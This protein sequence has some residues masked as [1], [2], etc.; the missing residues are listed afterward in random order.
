MSQH[1]HVRVRR[2]IAVSENGE[3][4]EEYDCRCGA[5]WTRTYEGGG[6]DPS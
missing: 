6:P 5:S 2:G 3:L 1:V 4:I